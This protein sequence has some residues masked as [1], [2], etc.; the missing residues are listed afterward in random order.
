[1]FGK[2]E[3]EGVEDKQ[4]ESNDN[5]DQAKDEINEMFNGN[6]KILTVTDPKALDLIKS[7]KENIKSTSYQAATK[8]LLTL[9]KMANE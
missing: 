1:M 6:V 8:D 9:F 7:I 5:L 4:E 3:P 2:G